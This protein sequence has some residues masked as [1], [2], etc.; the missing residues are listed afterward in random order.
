MQI[1][2]A[3]YWINS[4]KLQEHPEG[5]YY[6]E[7]FASNEL[8]SQKCLP[9]R[10]IGERFFYTSI[11]FLLKNKQVSHFH[12]I[13]SDEIS[14]FHSGNALDIHIIDENGN[15]SLKKTGLKF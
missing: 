15:Y 14:S 1:H 5:G 2:N 4:L 3:E 11:Y 7:I 8:I 9:K 6:R 10:F 13:K 12:R